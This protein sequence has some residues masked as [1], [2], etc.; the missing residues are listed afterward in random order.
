MGRTIGVENC[1]YGVYM[2]KTACQWLCGVIPDLITR[3]E[4]LPTLKSMEVRMTSV[5]NFSVCPSSIFA[6]QKVRPTPDISQYTIVLTSKHNLHTHPWQA[7][8]K[9]KMPLAD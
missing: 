6:S 4:V 2:A 5:C 7:R 8:G 3:Y 1:T 9:S